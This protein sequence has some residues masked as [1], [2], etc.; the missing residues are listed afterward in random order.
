MITNARDSRAFFMVED[1]VNTPRKAIVLAAGYG[2][3]LLPLTLIKPKP[4]FPVWGKPMLGHTLEL[5]HRWGVQEVLVNVHY[6]ADQIL[7]YLK[8]NPVP[9]LKYQVSFEPDILGTGGVLPKARWFVNDQPFWMLNAD[10]MADLEGRPL[11]K[12]FEKQAAIAAL[13]LDPARGPRTVEH[14]NGLIS[15]FRSPLAKTEGTATFC[16][17]Q[18]LSPEIFKYLPESGF[19]SIVDAYEN[20][21]VAGEKIAGVIV[22]HAY[23]ADIGN[24]EAYLTAHREMLDFP[25][26]KKFR[27]RDGRIVSSGKGIIIH[28]N[29]KVDRSVLWDNVTLLPGA[30]VQDAI[31]ADGVT[32]NSRASYMAVPA[33]RL[34]D[35]I[36]SRVLKHLKWQPEQT[37]VLPLPPRG[38]ARTFTRLICN[39][40]R[41]PESAILVRYSL[42]R[43]ENGL[44]TGQARFL[45]KH[46]VSVPSVLLDWPKE[47][48]CVLED[49]G[50]NSLEQLLPGLNRA[51]SVALYK[52][53]LD[54]VARL[55]TQATHSVARHP[56]QL[57]MP[58]T[59]H[60]YLW[61]QALF[62]DQFLHRHFPVND[63]QCQVIRKELAGL[64]PMQ[65]RAPR[66][67]VHRDL[68]S[69][70]VL[71]HKGLV[72]LIDFQGMR[73]G[74]A[75]YDLASLLCDPYV[76]LPDDVREELLDY[77]LGKVPNGKSIRALF[78][79]AAVE[80]LSQALGAY[81]RLGAAPA[82]AYFLKHIP[83]GITQLKKA[84]GH[85][86][87]L[88]TL[89][90]CLSMNG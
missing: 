72:F 82:T 35:I 33:D 71:V 84:L 62:C 53:T 11:I 60:L 54:N 63:A 5:L 67:I 89:K 18:L 7:A 37:T 61:E 73:M 41:K 81:G 64:I 12:A 50:E 85:V 38:S 36:I 87:G 25:R 80:R 6:H 55:H 2:S 77:Y 58:F 65:V 86:S 4:L 49:V 17:L 24:P 51:Q 39:A 22:P 66:V 44:Y 47:Q 88:P 69:S 34:P 29:A 68:Q 19:S 90:G 42:E 27:S 31:I 48:I 57:S 46:G 28:P 43:P 15:I 26:W 74:T 52:Q 3:R 13:W 21:L 8:T 14:R 10:V 16:G 75:A 1:K 20:A 56:I 70:N 83:A 30:C 79:I 23:W 40:R 9:G 45:A 32:L 78:W 76:N 59:R